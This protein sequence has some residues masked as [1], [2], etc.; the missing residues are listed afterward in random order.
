MERVKMDVLARHSRRAS[1][2]LTLGKQ[3]GEAANTVR[4]AN[5]DIAEDVVFTATGERAA[6]TYILFE[7]GGTQFAAG[8]G[9]RGFAEVLQRFWGHRGFG[10]RSFIITEILGSGLSL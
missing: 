9:V 1:A 7:G 8:F 5:A 4:A 6:P 2:Y 10:V 3:S